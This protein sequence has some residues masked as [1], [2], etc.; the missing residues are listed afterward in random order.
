MIRQD[1]ERRDW[2]VTPRQCIICRTT[3]TNYQT[4]GKHQCR[5][6]FGV[7]RNGEWTCCHLKVA[8]TIRTPQDFY[9]SNFSKPLLGCVECDHKE[10]LTPFSTMDAVDYRKLQNR[11]DAST[12]LIQTTLVERGIVHPISAAIGVRDREYMEIYRFS[13]RDVDAILA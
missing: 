8:K 1:Q 6:H 5:E 12:I 10:T 11:T 7:I 13:K 4:V 2:F 3:Y 9:A